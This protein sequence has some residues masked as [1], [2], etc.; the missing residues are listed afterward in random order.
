MMRMLAGAGPLVVAAGCM[1]GPTVQSIPSKAT[2]VALEGYTLS[3]SHDVRVDCKQVGARTTTSMGTTVSAA[4]PAL[5]ENGGSIYPWS[6]SVVVPAGCWVPVAPGIA[7]TRVYATDL[8]EGVRMRHVEDLVCAADEIA[9]GATPGQAGLA[10]AERFDH[11]ELRAPSGIATGT[12]PLT[13]MGPVQLLATGFGWA[14]GPLWDADDGSLVFTDIAADEIH[15]LK[16]GVLSTVVQGTNAYTNGL[17]HDAEGNRLECQHKLQRVIRRAANGTTTVVAASYQGLP[18]NSPND[19][20]AHA[21]GAIFFTDPTYGSLPN[22][23]GAVPQQPHQGVYRV[24]LD[25]GVVTLVDDDLQQPNGIALS[26]DHATL[27]VTDTQ[28]GVVMKYPVTAGGSVGAGTVLAT[29]GTPDGM[30]VDVNGNLYVTSATGVVVLK[31]DGTSWGTIG[32]PAAPTNV[33]F[34]GTDRKSLHVTT[35]TAVYRVALAVPGVPASF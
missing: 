18:F 8:D 33:A 4:A 30:A 31:P 17:D 3:P 24:A 12:N 9:E 28:G 29:V 2:A 26:P 25:T 6:K 35:P 27:Y 11:R 14:E 7:A 23:G 10:C 21:S 13:G 32:L 1:T 15:K 16:N 22:L 19:A 20:I 5:T 34:G